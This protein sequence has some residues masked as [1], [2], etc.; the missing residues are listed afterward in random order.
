MTLGELVSGLGDRSFGWCIVVFALVNLIPVPFGS[1]V[2]A[3]PL[4][5]ATAQM[6]LGLPE[7]RLPQPLMQRRIDRRRFQA[8]VMRVRPLL[9]PIE[10]LVRPRHP[11]VF[12]RQG[13]RAI[14]ALLLAVSIALFVPFPLSGY[15]PALALLVTGIGLV[16]RDGLVALAGLALGTVAVAV[17]AA[18]G[19]ALF[20]GVQLL[21]P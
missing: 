2:M 1:M 18:V 21:A 13:E 11:G 20:L 15:L 6:T 10:R 8:A 9:R 5:L 7:L 19:G 17:T 14:G 16:E 12:G 4:M 3:L